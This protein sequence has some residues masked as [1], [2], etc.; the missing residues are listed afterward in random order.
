MSVT[1]IEP[2]VELITPV[3]HLVDYSTLIELAGRT[4]YKSEDRIDKDSADRFIKGII[5][6]GH[7]SVVEHCSISYRF[8]CSRAASHQLIRHRISA[9]SQESQRYCDYGKLGFQVILPPKIAADPRSR[10]DFILA[11]EHAYSWY[12]TLR[13]RGIPPEDARFVLPNCSKTEVVTTFNLRMWRHVIKERGM[14][15]HAQWEIRSLAMAVLYELN[16]YLPS[17]FGDMV[18]EL[19]EKKNE[20]T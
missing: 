19:E 3:S 10:E 16:H 7:L 9:F 13:G 5:K 1:I 15:S 12:L 11:A 20:T 17:F 18:Q 8:T 6:A 4:C 14:N 2:K